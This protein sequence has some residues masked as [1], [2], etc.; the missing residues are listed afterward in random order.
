MDNQAVGAPLRALPA[1]PQAWQTPT[2]H[3]AGGMKLEAR[4]RGM[5]ALQDGRLACSRPD[6]QGAR[7]RMAAKG[8][9]LARVDF[10]WH[11]PHSA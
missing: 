7:V 6:R 10:G 3:D 1:R 8:E 9:L 2:A 4:R 5:G 11:P